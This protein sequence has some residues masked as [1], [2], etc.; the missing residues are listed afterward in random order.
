M[1]LCPFYTWLV[2]T[3][4]TNTNKQCSFY[5]MLQKN[6]QAHT[7][8]N[9]EH[10]IEGAGTLCMNT[11]TTKAHACSIAKQ[12]LLYWKVPP[13]TNTCTHKIQRDW[14]A[15]VLWRSCVIRASVCLN[16]GTLLSWEIRS[17]PSQWMCSFHTLSLWITA[18]DILVSNCHAG[19]FQP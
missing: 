4:N 10:C 14:V 3:K 16:V 13:P 17:R 6:M 11:Q 1:M 7:Q 15:I 18:K 5:S 2:W 12:R 19:E 8:G 9:K